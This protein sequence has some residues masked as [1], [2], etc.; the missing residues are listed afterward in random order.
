V[1]E[2]Q[3]LLEETDDSRLRAL[4][5]AGRADVPPSEFQGRLMLG[6]GLGAATIGGVSSAAA[7]SVGKSA[8][9]PAAA[10]AKLAPSA[11][12][13]VAKWV[14]V[15]VCSGGL[16]A[17]GAELLTS[18]RAPLEPS[19]RAV[20]SARTSTRAG[21]SL[22][23]PASTGA[24]EQ[25]D[26]LPTLEAESEAAQA[27]LPSTPAPA[28]AASERVVS[29]VQLIDAA[30]QALA[31]GQFRQALSQLDVYD[32]SVKSGVLLREARVLRIEALH[33]D[34]ETA[35]ARSLS[36]QYLREFPQDAH[37]PRL[38]SLTS[39]TKAR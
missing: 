8:L 6:L 34:G 3:P 36:Q 16:L 2:L 11:V 35:R 21:L 38:R 27:A 37:A 15:G 12:S 17:G 20:A 29:E 28:P 1:N 32:R 23:P 5:E 10:A 24:N 25:I 14:V 39:P 31:Q 4:L 26:P 13:L 7:A 18:R 9:S 33:R 19:V 22:P 30:R